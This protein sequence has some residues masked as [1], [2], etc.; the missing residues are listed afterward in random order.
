MSTPRLPLLPRIGFLFLMVMFPLVLA[1]IVLLFFAVPDERWTFVLPG[2]GM[3][4]GLN[5]TRNARRAWL[6]RHRPA[7]PVVPSAPGSS[8]AGAQ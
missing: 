6:E 7:A 3:L 8:A 4:M 2:L 1:V 5:W